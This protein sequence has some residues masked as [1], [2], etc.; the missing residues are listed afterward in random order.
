[1]KNTNPRTHKILDKLPIFGS[2]LAT[3]IF[4]ALFFII[5]S[6]ANQVFEAFLLEDLCSGP[7]ILTAFIITNLLFVLWFRGETK[8]LCL[9]GNIRGAAVV[10]VMYI[11]YWILSVALGI[12]IS[13][14]R[15]G[16][17]KLADINNAV[18]AGFMEETMIRGFIL[19]LLFRKKRTPRMI[20]TSMIVTSVIFAML[21]APNILA[22][23]DLGAT[24]MQV[25]SS[26]PTGFCFAMLYV[27]SGNILPAIVMHALHD[28]IAFSA[29]DATEGG[30][31]VAAVDAG[32][33]VNLLLCYIL[34]AICFF[35]LKKE[36][37]MNRTIEIWDKKWDK[38][39][40]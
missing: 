35:Y 8:G 27:C 21:H 38:V 12:I 5:M 6:I 11:I 17:P 18:S 25:A 39:S 19:M 23:A 13:G 30:V 33:W 28:I 3:G 24:V 15:Y 37:I 36:N 22:G 20:I 10:V 32:S 16:L 9:G 14:D 31:M 40:S 29:I 34:A 7:A 4:V 26:I 2:I 1:M